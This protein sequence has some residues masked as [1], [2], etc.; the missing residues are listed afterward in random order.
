METSSGPKYILR[1]FALRFFKGTHVLCSYMDPRGSGKDHE[2][3]LS[4]RLVQVTGLR[5]LRI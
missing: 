2:K 3:V 1:D 4:I 5:R